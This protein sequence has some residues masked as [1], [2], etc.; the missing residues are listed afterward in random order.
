MSD[1][2]PPPDAM[3][4]DLLDALLADLF[5]GGLD[6]ERFRALE[7]LVR[8]DPVA[9]R[10]YRR[11]V[12]LHAALDSELLHP[13]ERGPEVSPSAAVAPP[14]NS[15]N[16]APQQ[17]AP[18][19]SARVWRRSAWALTLL[20]LGLL[21][22]AMLAPRPHAMVIAV[23][24]AEAADGAL[25]LPGQ[26]LAPRTWNLARG[27][28]HLRLHAGASVIIRAPATFAVTGANAVSLTTG[29]AIA[30]VPHA[31]SGFVIATPHA[32]VIDLG[33]AFS[34]AVEP[35]T[36]TAIHV[37]R[38]HVQVA[39]TGSPTPQ[40]VQAG[41]ARAVSLAGQVTSAPFDAAIFAQPVVV[42]VA[43]PRSPTASSPPVPGSLRGDPAL[44]GLYGGGVM[45]QTSD[46]W[47]SLITSPSAG[48]A[49]IAHPSWV[50]GRL[51]GTQALAFTRPDQ[52]VRLDIP[53]TFTRVT[54]W[55]WVQ[56][57]SLGPE[58]TALF[59]TDGWGSPP[60][61]HW[62]CQPDG[63]LS[64]HLYAPSGRIWNW[65]S[66]RAMPAPS[67]RWHHL[68]VTCGD[69]GLVRFFCDG[70]LL[71]EQQQRHQVGFSIGPA[72]IGNWRAF[73]RPGVQRPSGRHLTGAVGE[74][75]VVGREATIAEI[76]ELA[77]VG[78]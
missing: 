50:A 56:V 31:A 65:T 12:R 24:D 74:F 3:P 33:T 68:A 35:R 8:D 32:R 59:A 27:T 14:R 25:P 52:H 30:E 22:I 6:A 45:P 37:L 36:G 60:I 46:R 44:I 64:F 2:A 21:G 58:P 10:R 20:L 29:L 71:G 41:E 42:P 43:A 18:L 48:E 73:A 4:G 69:S 16:V 9:R 75:G 49:I 39:T 17:R 47:Q 38:G 72:Q 70:E 13:L 57:E 15:S 76:R 1:P 53:G 23:Q 55:A 61:V 54:L 78:R 77:D 34:V 11:Y 67:A 26:P 28:L 63:R 40:H 19:R 66:D 5:D 51:P 7:A 62:M